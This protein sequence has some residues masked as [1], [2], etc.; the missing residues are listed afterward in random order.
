MKNICHTIDEYEISWDID[1][2]TTSL[3][4]VVDLFSNGYEGDR[5]HDAA[6]FLGGYWAEKGNPGHKPWP[7]KL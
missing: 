5:P 2:L 1:D 4:S 7:C 3:P 6:I